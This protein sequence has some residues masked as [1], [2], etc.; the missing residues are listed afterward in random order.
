MLVRVTY[1][2]NNQVCTLH[3]EY[4]GTRNGMLIV[5]GVPI[6]EGAVLANGFQQIDQSTT[7]V[8]RKVG[9]AVSLDCSK[10]DALPSQDSRDMVEKEVHPAGQGT[11]D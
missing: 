7:T 8:Y 2:V 5:G 3:G 9:E 4:G 11:Q 10:D 6:P 1:R